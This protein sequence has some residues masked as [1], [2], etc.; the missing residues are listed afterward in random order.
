MI[1]RENKKECGNIGGK[2][3]KFKIMIRERIERVRK[4]DNMYRKRLKR[5]RRSKVQIELQ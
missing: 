2:K 3:H 5:D 4:L 1:N